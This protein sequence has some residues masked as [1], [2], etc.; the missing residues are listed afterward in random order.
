MTTP[1]LD[2]VT[3]SYRA[4]LTPLDEQLTA[5]CFPLMK[6]YPALHCLTRA[7]ASGAVRDGTLVVESSSGTL[8]LG[9]AVV[10]NVLR[11]PLCIVTDHACDD[12]LMARLRDLGAAVERVT[13]PLADGGYQRARLE[14]LHEICRQTPDHWWLNQYDNPDNAQSYEAFADQLAAAVPDL[15]C[16]VGAV[17]SGGSLCG[18]ARRLRQRWPQ[19]RVVAVDTFHSVL[20]GQPDGPRVLRGLGNSLLPGNLDHTQVD[21][22]HWMTAAT[23]YTA[24]RH[25]HRHTSLFRG[26]TSG[27]VW[28]A[29]RYEARRDPQARVAAIFPDDGHRYVR[30]VYDDQYLAERGLWLT[31]LPEQPRVVTRPVDTD[32]PHE[33]ATMAWGRRAYA[34]VAPPREGTTHGPGHGHGHGHGHGPG[35]AKGPNGGN[36]AGTSRAAGTHTTST[37]DTNGAKN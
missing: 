10:C 35:S 25:L 14:R 15:T 28:L 31:A 16:V 20:F 26:A 27:A 17:G 7:R 23:A 30:D 22:V 36:G 34:A 9:L 19:V 12:V 11:Q 2:A 6:F 4:T 5:A 21:A 33:W 13:A 18:T 32:A 24:T 37:D 8:A 29:A 3:E 1:L